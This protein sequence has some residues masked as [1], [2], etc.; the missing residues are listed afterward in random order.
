ILSLYKTT[1]TYMH[2]AFNHWIPRLPIGIG[3]FLHRWNLEK[4]KKKVVNLYV[5]LKR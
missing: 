5:S 4:E 1:G 2:A 3:T